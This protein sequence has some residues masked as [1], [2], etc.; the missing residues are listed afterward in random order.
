MDYRG[1]SSL[2]YIIKGGQ[3]IF[4]HVTL[5]VTCRLHLTMHMWWILCLPE[6]ELES[7]SSHI[8]VAPCNRHHCDPHLVYMLH[9]SIIFIFHSKNHPGYLQVLLYYWGAVWGMGDFHGNV[10]KSMKIKVSSHWYYTYNMRE[11]KHKFTTLT[12]P[13][14][15]LHTQCK[16]LPFTQLQHSNTTI[17][18]TSTK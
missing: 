4:L 18:Y 5:N 9:N 6:Q 1:Y 16:L 14:Q 8:H 3:L 15:I 13:I 11:K 2:Q 12:S 17:P 10:S 7:G